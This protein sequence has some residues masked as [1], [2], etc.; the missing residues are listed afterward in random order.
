VIVR[1]CAP[2]AVLVGSLAVSLADDPKTDPKAPPK[3]PPKA[4]DGW[5]YVESKDK[6]YQFLFPEKSARSG[7]RESSSRRAGLSL[8][9]QINYAILADGTQLTMTAS[10]MSGSALK[11]LTIG[12]VYKNS[13]EGLK[14]DNASVS[15]PKEVEVSGR[16]GK[17]VQISGK[18]GIEQR[19]VLLVVKGR[20]YEIVVASKDKAKLTGDPAD[21]FLKSLFIVPKEAPAA[22]D[23]EKKSDKP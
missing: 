17:E 23:G 11:G 15:E 16:K 9:Q 8:K 2:L 14:E 13:F 1:L 22:K 6:S 7:S 3:T 10:N 5:K 21:T 4:P 12:E 18:D 19:L 20:M